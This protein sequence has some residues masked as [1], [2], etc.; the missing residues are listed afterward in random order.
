VVRRRGLR[1]GVAVHAAFRAVEWAT[2]RAVHEQR[3]DLL[4][5]S[6]AASA[7]KSDIG[8]QHL[9]RRLHS[10]ASPARR[11]AMER[12]LLP[13]TRRRLCW[14]CCVICGRC[15]RRRRTERFSAA[16]MRTVTGRADE[17]VHA[18]CVAA[19]LPANCGHPPQAPPT[20]ECAGAAASRTKSSAPHDTD[21]GLASPLRTRSFSSRCLLTRQLDPADAG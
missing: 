4:I 5:D 7:R 8:Q 9:R 2:T 3:A 16:L 11:G 10:S 18:W 6:A 12:H 17:S 20:I 13:G 1:N 15:W 19:L 21:K 14:G